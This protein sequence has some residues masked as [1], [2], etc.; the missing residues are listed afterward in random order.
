[1][2]ALPQSRSGP[3]STTIASFSKDK[4]SYR[5]V[6]VDQPVSQGNGKSVFPQTQKTRD[7]LAA[8]NVPL[9]IQ[10]FKNVDAALKNKESLDQSKVASSS[11]KTLDK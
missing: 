3:F 7:T 4:I 6:P 10:T 8:M 2:I 1:M 11:K 9:T 5:T